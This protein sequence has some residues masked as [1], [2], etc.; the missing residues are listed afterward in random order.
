MQRQKST[1]VRRTRRHHA[2]SDIPLLIKLSN[3]AL[4]GPLTTFYRGSDRPNSFAADYR[5]TRELLTFQIACIR[6]MDLISGGHVTLS[7]NW[8]FF[9]F[10][11]LSAVGDAFRKQRGLISHGQKE[12][13]ASFSTGEFSQVTNAGKSISPPLILLLI[14]SQRKLLRFPDK[15]LTS[16]A[17]SFGYVFPEVIKNM[18]HGNPVDIWWT[19]ITTLRMHR[20]TTS[21][22]LSL[23]SHHHLCS[24]LWR[25]PPFMTTPSPSP[26]KT[27]IP[28]SSLPYWSSVS[29]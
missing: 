7:G 18:G 12:Q 19:G 13:L 10:V 20:R 6:E 22:F 14:F 9:G 26:S 23:H 27:A 28:K 29:D 11:S 16:L 25:T 3:M 21:S 5:V 24:P 8:G 4:M 2:H 15:Q 17:S 1:S